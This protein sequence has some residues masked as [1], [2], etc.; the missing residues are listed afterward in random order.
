MFRI[1]KLT[2]Y[3]MVVM[4]H[5]AQRPKELHTA[6]GLT[7]AT[8][9]ALP[10]VTKILKIFARKELLTSQRGV[11]GG[12]H[13]AK[14]PDKITLAEIIQAIEGE[15]GLTECSQSD[16]HCVLEST[17]RTRKNWSLISELIL[18][19]LGNIS[20]AEMAS[21]LGPKDF[22]KKLT[23]QHQAESDE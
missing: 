8:H 11:H 14:S 9:L 5:L 16:S 12:Y 10:T 21:S 15:L 1:S 18:N 4:T 7:E 22:L 3:G 17:C 6:R 23:L 2:D 19:A 13:L 20:L